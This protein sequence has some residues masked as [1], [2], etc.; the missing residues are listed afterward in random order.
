MKVYVVVEVYD[1]EWD[2]VQIYEYEDVFVS[3]GDALAYINQRDFC[4]EYKII[5]KEFT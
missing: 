3:K 4:L 2:A 1:H 5:E